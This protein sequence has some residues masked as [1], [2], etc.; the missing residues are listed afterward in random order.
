[1]IKLKS[2]R[3]PASPFNSTVITYFAGKPETIVTGECI[4]LREREPE[5][6]VHLRGDNESVSCSMC[7][8]LTGPQ[9]PWMDSLDK[10]AS[11]PMRC[12]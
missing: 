11:H 7:G 10:W 3:V 2:H 12:R 9:A 5:E 8:N 6:R 4:G 1:M